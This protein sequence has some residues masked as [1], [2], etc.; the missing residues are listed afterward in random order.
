MMSRKA[1]SL[2]AC[3]LLAVSCVLRADGPAWRL[4][5]ARLELGS[6]PANRPPSSELV[7]VNGGDAP[8]EGVRVRTGC[9]CLSAAAEAASVPPGGQI[10]IR[11]SVAPEAVSGKFSHSVFVE[12]GGE[13]RRVSV[14]GEAV[15]LLRVRPASVFNAGEVVCG[16]TLKAEFRLEGQSDFSPGDMSGDLRGEAF[17]IAPG[18]YRVI[19]QGMAPSVPGPFRLKASVEVSSPS[20]WR[21]I[22]LVV[23]GTAVAPPVLPESRP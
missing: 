16:E 10:A 17:R 7:L 9:G 5:P 12:A 14:T 20:G 13:F 6:F 19:V 8:L 22:E 3:L 1:H 11:L 15:P 23:F 4:E 21:P 2:L 18:S